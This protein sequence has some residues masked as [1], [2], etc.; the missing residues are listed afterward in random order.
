MPLIARSEAA[1]NR[2]HELFRASLTG[3]EVDTVA[4]SGRKGGF[5]GDVVLVINADDPRW[6]PP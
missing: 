1:G 2:L 3:R 4:R 5:P 6:L